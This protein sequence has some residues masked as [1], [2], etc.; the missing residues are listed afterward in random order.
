MNEDLTTLKKIVQKTNTDV[1]N[2]L[3]NLDKRDR[4]SLLIEHMEHLCFPFEE[5]EVW[6][7]PKLKK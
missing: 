3:H 6:V 1:I 7:V 2:Q 4:C 5:E